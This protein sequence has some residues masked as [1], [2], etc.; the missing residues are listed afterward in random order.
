LIRNHKALVISGGSPIIARRGP[1]LGAASLG[2]IRES[3]IL[4]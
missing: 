4:R 2:N 3:G 1:N